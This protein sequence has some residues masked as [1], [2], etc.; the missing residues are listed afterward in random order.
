MDKMCSKCNQVKNVT[1]FYKRISRPDGLQSNC[2]KC[3]KVSAR[4][5][6]IKNP[7]DHTKRNAYHKEYQRKLRAKIAKPPRKN[8]ISDGSCKYYIKLKNDE[9]KLLNH[10]ELY[11]KVLMMMPTL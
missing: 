3:C 8:V 11:R 9:A 1:E 5:N 4:L 6:R 2:K 10:S 7:Q